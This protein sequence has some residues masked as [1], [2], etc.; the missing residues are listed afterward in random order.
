MK[1]YNEE[2]V[3]NQLKDCIDKSNKILEDAIDWKYESY[4]KLHTRLRNDRFC[5]TQFVSKL[6]GINY[7]E[8]INKLVVDTY[9]GTRFDK[10]MEKY[11]GMKSTIVETWG[12]RY[13]IEDNCNDILRDVNESDKVFIHVDDIKRILNKPQIACWYCSGIEKHN[14]AYCNHFKDISGVEIF[15]VDTP[16][17]FCPNCGRKLEVEEC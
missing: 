6:L 9:Y 2:N 13:A 7:S 14:I 17:N 12:K 5:L 8:V 4:M 15:N 1:L 10:C 11:K 16:Y 3:L